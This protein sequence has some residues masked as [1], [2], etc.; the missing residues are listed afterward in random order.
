[1]APTKN[2]LS[3]YQKT[4]TWG[5]SL[6]WWLHFKGMALRSLRVSGCKLARH[7]KKISISQHQRKNLQLEA[8]YGKYSKKRKLNAIL[9]TSIGQEPTLVIVMRS[10]VWQSMMIYILIKITDRNGEKRHFHSIAF[11]GNKILPL[12]GN[13]SLYCGPLN[14]TQQQILK[15]LFIHQSPSEWS[16]IGP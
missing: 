10:N 11:R 1:M 15:S 16:I 13:L 4:G 5:C 7:F 9:V 12:S 3:P 8:L 2:N 14:L 6:P